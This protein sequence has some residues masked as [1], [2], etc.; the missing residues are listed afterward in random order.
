MTHT[1]PSA[2]Q[3]TNRT[4]NFSRPRPPLNLN[5]PL[6]PLPILVRTN[7]MVGRRVGGGDRGEGVRVRKEGYWRL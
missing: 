6:P 3:G 4:Y 7:G 1:R 5:K 2:V